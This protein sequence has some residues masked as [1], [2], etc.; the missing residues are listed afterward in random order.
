M[1]DISMCANKECP[2]R[3][4]CYRHQASGTRPSDYQSMMDFK[5]EPGEDKCESFWDKAER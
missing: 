3:A 5:P 4:S 1:P 2:S